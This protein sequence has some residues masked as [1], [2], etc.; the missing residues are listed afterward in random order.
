MK[1][2][3][4]G[5][6]QAAEKAADTTLATT[7]PQMM[8]DAGRGV[9]EAIIERYDVIDKTV[10][11]LVGSGNNGGDGLICGSHLRN[12]GAN[13]VYFI[14]RTPSNGTIDS[15]SAT[16]VLTDVNA[17]ITKLYK[18][19]LIVDALFGWGLSRPIIGDLAQLMHI[20]GGMSPRP[21]IIAVDCP[22]GVN[23]DSGVVDPAT[24][25]A[26]LTVTFAGAKH[27]HFKFPAAKFCGEIAVAD[28]GIPPK[29]TAHINTEMVTPAAMRDLLPERPL[30]GHKGTFGRVL[31]VG[32]CSDYTGA[33]ILSGRS[34]FRAGSGLVRMVVPESVRRTAQILLPE[35]TFVNHDPLHNLT[36]TL[37]IGCV[38]AIRESDT[39]AML[40][41]PGLGES[42]EVTQLINRLLNRSLI[43]P[44]TKAF[45]EPSQEPREPG[46][47]KCVWD[48]SA[49][50][51]IAKQEQ[52]WEYLDPDTILTP[53]PGEMARLVGEKITGVNRIDL[54][55][56]YAEKWG[57]VVVLKGAYTVVGRPDGNVTLIPI[58]NPLLAT[59]GSGDVLAGVIV[60][61]LGQGVGVGDAAV[62]GAYLHGMAGNILSKKY[63]TAGLLA[64]ELADAIPVARTQ[65]TQC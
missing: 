24:V 25:P 26:D 3:S 48:A 40:I 61:L 16:A 30:D 46:L 58:A 65:L 5:E 36:H 47:G 35:A 1:I 38:K 9:A 32:G 41:G 63:G 43:A 52:W 19:D 12:S 50:N 49:L 33:P 2:F 62:L 28:I 55:R 10:L 45:R 14:P 22:S 59:A 18:V 42:G 15:L 54:V 53:H 57:V 39:H 60:S 21:P 4:I 7:Y 8:A 64:S 37:N 44:W 11:I 20:I 29:L 31:V 13:I 23:L 51:I 17:V 56:H 6:M 34:A 27:G